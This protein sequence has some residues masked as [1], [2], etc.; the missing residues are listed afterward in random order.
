MKEE[1]AKGRGEIEGYRVFKE[2]Q[3]REPIRER[4]ICI[5]GGEP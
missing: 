1:E 3:H 4:G 2:D 5:Y